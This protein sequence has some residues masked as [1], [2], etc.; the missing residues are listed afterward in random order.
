M[1]ILFRHGTDLTI[2]DKRGNTAVTL[3]CEKVAMVEAEAWNTT[4]V[5]RHPMKVSKVKDIVNPN[6]GGPVDSRSRS[7]E[8]SNYHTQLMPSTAPG[9]SRLYCQACYC[10]LYYAI[11]QA[12]KTALYVH[13][14]DQIPR[15]GADGRHHITCSYSRLQRHQITS[16]HS[17]E[18]SMNE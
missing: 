12:Q 9:A 3:A 11:L 4:L 1:K 8:H 10:A 14:R 5:A 2:R 15:W 17:K 16:H 13:R 7:G 18:H 6:S